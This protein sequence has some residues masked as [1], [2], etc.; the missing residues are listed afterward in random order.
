MTSKLP[1][2][3]WPPSLLVAEQLRRKMIHTRQ[4]ETIELVASG[5]S[6]TAVAAIMEISATTVRNRLQMLYVELGISVL[7]HVNPRVVVAVTAAMI[8]NAGI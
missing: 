2:P 3:L 7:P 5:Y 8:R 1:S 6:N 4:R